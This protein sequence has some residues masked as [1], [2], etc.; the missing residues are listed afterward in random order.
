MKAMDAGTK[1]ISECLLIF[2]QTKQLKCDINNSSIIKACT[3]LSIVV[4]PVAIDFACNSPQ[5]VEAN[6]SDLVAPT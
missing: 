6:H 4:F 1:R 3:S 2:L 5:E